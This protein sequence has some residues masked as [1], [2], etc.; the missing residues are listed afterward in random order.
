MTSTP[1][2]FYFRVSRANS[3]IFALLLVVSS[4]TACSVKKYA[5]SKLGDSLA[6]QSSSSFATDDD[7]ELVGD[8]LTLRAQADGRTS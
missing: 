5:I 8:A 7:P 2:P 6:S 3:L 4:S 1:R